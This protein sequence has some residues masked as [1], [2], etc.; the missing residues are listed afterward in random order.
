MAML[1]EITDLISAL[2]F[3]LRNPPQNERF[4]ED[5]SL[6][7][8]I[9]KLTQSLNLDDASATRVFDSVLEYSVKTIISVL[10]SSISCNVFPL[11]SKEVLGVG[12]SISGRDCFSLIEAIGDTLL[13]LEEHGVPSYSLLYAVLRVIV[14]APNC[15][16]LAQS[17]VVLDSE[18]ST[19]RSIAASKLVS[20]LPEEC[21]FVKDQVPA[22]LLFWFLDPL[23]LKRDISEILQELVNRPFLSL[24][25]EFHER[26]NWRSI[27]ICLVLSPVMFT[28]TRDLLHDWFL[29]TGL[30]SI[31]QLLIDLVSAVLDAICTPERWGISV[32]LGS[33]LPFSSAYFP[34]N[35]FWLSSLAGPISCGTLLR[36]VNGTRDLADH[37]GKQLGHAVKPSVTKIALLDDKSLWSLAISFPD[38]FSF[39]SVLL[40]ADKSFHEMVQL[41]GNVGDLRFEQATGAEL[42]TN[43]AAGYLAWILNP[44]DKTHQD[45]LSLSLIKLTGHWNKK[46]A[47]AGGQDRQ[48]IGS[49]KRLK[50]PKLDNKE[51]GFIFGNECGRQAVVLWLKEYQ[52]MM[53]CVDETVG[54][55]PSYGKKYRFDPEHN[56]F[57]RWIPLGIITG[58]SNDI[59]ES[60]CELLLHYA[61]TGNILHSDNMLIDTKEA[62]AGASLVFNLTDIA[63]RMFESLFET[64]DI[65]VS[66]I[67]KVK[68][69]SSRYLIKCV[70]RLTVHDA[71]EDRVEILMDLHSRLERWNHQGQGVPLLQTEIDDCMIALKSKIPSI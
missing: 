61:A 38:W 64:A 44:T 54:D 58:W 16:Y 62:I 32:T 49:R 7:L 4:E 42:H 2:A 19:G 68:S 71:G 41:K 9:S 46:K 37:P 56:M 3:Q 15:R 70:Q 30:S 39:A 47:S 17:L 53:F 50:K 23:I 51:G 20:H 24:C 33:K 21:S 69:R 45:R 67:S 25:K 12:S 1:E 22:R 18:L 27:L 10:S 11:G 34:F 29:L 43:A 48:T 14:S 57:F 28:D 8:S 35:N 13:S 60:G 26:M 6:D 59:K 66:Y 5:S 63:D 65:A 36:F 40:F 52:K 55:T 31:L